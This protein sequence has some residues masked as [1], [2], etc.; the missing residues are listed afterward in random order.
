MASASCF[1][2]WLNNSTLEIFVYILNFS[3]RKIIKYGK[4]FFI[5]SSD[6]LS[7]GYLCFGT[8]FAW[9]IHTTV[10]NLKKNG[11]TRGKA[12]VDTH[13]NFQGRYV[14]P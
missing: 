7:I 11:R 9:G 1:I 8:T 6:C 10:G 5:N 14:R 2:S 3:I 12:K 13:H 4:I